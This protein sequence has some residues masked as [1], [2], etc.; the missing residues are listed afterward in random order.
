VI[1]VIK[2]IEMISGFLLLQEKRRKENAAC[3]EQLS[4]GKSCP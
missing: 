4:P 2:L 1:S 3:N